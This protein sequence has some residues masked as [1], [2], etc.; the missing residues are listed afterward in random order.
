M[1]MAPSHPVTVHN[2]HLRRSLPGYA[3]P[4]SAAEVRLL[5]V[6]ERRLIATKRLYGLYSVSPTG[7]G[8]GGF[9]GL[10][11]HLHSAASA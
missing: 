10:P 8:L 1:M 11:A 7:R 6:L 9:F 2:L 3:E 5:I 4:I